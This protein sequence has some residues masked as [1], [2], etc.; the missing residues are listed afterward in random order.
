MKKLLSI[1]LTAALLTVTMLSTACDIGSVAGN[2]GIGGNGTNVSQNSDN[3]GNTTS[4]GNTSS[5]TSAVP[6]EKPD[7]GEAVEIEETEELPFTITYSS[8]TE[9]AYTVTYYTGVDEYTVLFKEITENTVYSMSGTL[10]G[11]IVADADESE[12]YKFELELTGLNVE[13]AVNAPIA[14]LSGDKFSLS[15]KKGTTN[16][17][18]DSRP[19]V[20]SDESSYSSAIYSKVDLDLKGKGSLEVTSV[21]NNGIHTKDDLDVKNLTLTVSCIDNALKGNDGVTIESGTI[22]LIARQGDAIKTSNSAVKYNEDGSVKKVQGTVSIVGGTV[23][24]YAA[25]DGIDAAYNVVIADDA[26]A[27]TSPVIDIYTDKYSQYSEEVTAASE[28]TYYIR[29]TSSAYKYSVYYY[30][31]DTDYKWVNSTYLTSVTSGGGGGPWGGG[32]TTYY[33]HTVAKASGYSRFILYVYT[34]AQTQGQSD[35]Y[36]AVSQNKA[37]SDSYDTIAVSVGG[38]TANLSWTNYTTQ[39]QGP[40]GPGGFQEGNPD[41]G[42]YSTKGIKSDNEILI[43]GGTINVKSYDDAIHTN[44]DVTLGDEDDPTDDYIGTGNIVVS[45]GTL[46]L[47]SNDDGVHADGTLTVSGGTVSVT[48][49]Y[50]G[51]EGNVIVVSGGEIKLKASDDGVNATAESGT[52][53]TVSGGYLYVYSGGDGIDSNSK[54][55]YSGIKFTGGKTVVVST[56][57]GNSCIDTEQGYTYSGGYVLAICPT[58]M[59]NEVTKYNKTAGYGTTKTGSFSNGSYVVVAGVVAVKMP[60]GISN[61]FAIYL[62]ETSGSITTASSASYTLDDNGVYWN[63]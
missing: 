41:K 1:I 42:D 4:S 58:G 15:A 3:G 50:E 19:D 38:S 30:N 25:C 35:N 60:V 59:T 28:S 9:N 27:G 7:L 29:S 2:G 23:T 13:S 18:T 32:R 48:N 6:Y 24:C 57:G 55:S 33:Y 47:Y 45:G 36:A 26:K 16:V 61:G 44:N 37:L 63:V 53:I 5:E 12:T 10:K 11:N 31:S 46:T 54:T 22:T 43:S 34:S 21:N 62:G 8:G 39:Q 17:V 51:L 56:S 49:S 20:S 40:G 52:A 14:A